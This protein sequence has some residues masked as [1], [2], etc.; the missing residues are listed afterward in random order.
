MNVLWNF[1]IILQDE[2]DQI[3]WLMESLTLWRGEAAH[4]I[5]LTLYN[6][7]ISVIAFKWN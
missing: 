5:L 7:L 6:V 1:F 4:F 3:L 2:K